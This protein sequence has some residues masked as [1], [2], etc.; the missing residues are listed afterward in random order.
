MNRAAVSQRCFM[1]ES[2]V[3]DEAGSSAELD[4]V[5]VEADDES[6][7][8]WSKTGLSPTVKAAGVFGV[9]L[10]V[11]VFL[12]L[13]SGAG[14]AFVYS[15]LVHEVMTNPVAFEGRELRVEG[16]LRSGSIQFRDEPCEWRFVLEQEGVSM[17]V[18][19][20]QCV[21]PDTF[22]DGFGIR[23]TVQGS[24][25]TEGIFQANQVVPRCPSKYEMEQRIDQGE[26]APHALPVA[27]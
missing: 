5:D 22:R 26:Q 14:D 17:P 16:G 23:V 20:S 13:G 27:S 4:D 15:K 6:R 8:R 19:F 25:D 21:V 24:L 3:T 11:V 10:S 9:L 2:E 18:R 7:A 1:H 12:S